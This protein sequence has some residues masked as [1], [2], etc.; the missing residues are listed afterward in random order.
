[1]AVKNGKLIVIE[2]TDGSGK[3]TQSKLLLERLNNG[4]IISKT[5]SFPDYD[6]PTG[7][8]ISM[9]L[10][11]NGFNREFGISN[12]VNPKIAST[13]YAFDRFSK[14]HEIEYSLENNCNVILDRYVDSN[15]GHQGGKFINPEERN[16]FFDWLYWLEYNNFG[17]PKPDIT[18]FLYMPY[19]MSNA[20]RINRGEA[21]DGHESSEVHLRR[22]E[23]SYLSL[24]KRNEWKKINCIDNSDNLRTKEDI[25]EE[26]YKKVIPVLIRD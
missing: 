23:A 19:E 15:A 21:E 9:Y 2:G 16:A 6:S 12:E 17:M 7:K 3:K 14:K 8:V 4:G 26:V 25:S 24:V 20:L 1:M 11:K 22:A 5:F 18:I 13:W 10:G